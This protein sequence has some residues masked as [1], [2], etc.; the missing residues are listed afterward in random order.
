MNRFFYSRFALKNIKTNQKLTV[1]YMISSIFSIAIF[2]I[3]SSLANNSNL[4]NIKQGAEAIKELLKYGMIVIAIFIV[5]F[6]FYSYSF[7]V[8]K[9]YSE[10]GLYSVLGMTK[11]QISK[12]ILMENIILAFVTVFVGILVG[13]VFDKLAYLFLLKL[14]QAKV[15]LGFYISFTAIKLTVLLFSLIYILT[16][17]SS[18]IKIY[19][20][21][22]IKLLKSDNVGEKEPKTRWLL[23][24]VGI[25]LIGYGYYT[26]LIIKTPLQALT[27]FFYAVVSVIIGTYLLFI[28]ISIFVLKLLKNNKKLYYK[29]QNFISIS[30]MIYRMK[31]NAVGLANICILSTMILITLGSTASLYFGK[32]ALVKSIYPRSV[33][34]EAMRYDEK[35]FSKLQSNIDNVIKKEGVKK[36]NIIA[37]RYISI[38]AK[39]T[40]NGLI[41]Q[42]DTSNLSTLTSAIV[43]PLEDYN[44]TYNTNITLK[45]NEILLLNS[46]SKE[47]TSQLKINNQEFSVKDTVNIDSLKTESSSVLDT[48]H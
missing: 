37:H 33:T 21:N 11:K 40:D 20:L 14:M 8:K 34:I 3:L 35:S 24:L 23:S 25:A 10:F 27:N 38:Y 9:R 26:A 16:I 39:K 43:I 13:I 42:N 17:I 48:Y 18:L 36:E 12:I 32:E 28:A 29:T 41:I 2:Y 45:D 19:R 31:R 44:K 5:I 6:I 7:L 47:Q 15:E 22:I 4:S 30:N 1:P 46:R